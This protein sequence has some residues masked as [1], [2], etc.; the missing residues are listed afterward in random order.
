MMEKILDVL[1]RQDGDALARLVL[2]DI[3]ELER[4]ELQRADLRERGVRI[5]RSNSLHE[6]LH[7]ERVLTPRLNPCFL[8][9]FPLQLCQVHVEE[10]LHRRNLRVRAIATGMEAVEVGLPGVLGIG[11]EAK[12]RVLAIARLASLA[13]WA[14]AIEATVSLNIV[15]RGQ[16]F[17]GIVILVH[18]QP[19]NE[20]LEYLGAR[21]TGSDG[22]EFVTDRPVLVV[23]KVV[24]FRLLHVGYMES[25]GSGGSGDEGVQ[26]EEL[27]PRRVS[28]GHVENKSGSLVDILREGMI[29]CFVEID[30]F[31][32]QSLHVQFFISLI[33][34]HL[35]VLVQVLERRVGDL[36]ERLNPLIGADIRE[37]EAIQLGEFLL[38]CSEKGF[39]GMFLVLLEVHVNSEDT[40]MPPRCSVYTDEATVGVV[41]CTLAVE[42]VVIQSGLA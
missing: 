26:I 28:T 38:R 27:H 19:R 22:W 23:L 21:R 2:S 24:R 11:I 13:L 42:G 25:R 8:L 12:V 34:H 29:Y 5:Y 17:G 18:L 36:E 32:C 15:H 31:I 9:G 1:V 16:S 37:E 14:L 6:A 39:R 41:S 3:G 35:R 30:A 4:A 20:V 7:Q 40:R 33:L 10:P